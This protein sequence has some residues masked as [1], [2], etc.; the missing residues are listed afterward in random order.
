MTDRRTF[1]KGMTA[2]PAT[3]LLASQTGCTAVDEAPV[4]RD[5]LKELGV[6]PFINAAAAYS[7]LGGRNMWPAVVE[8]MEY[9]RNQNVIME[10]LQEAVG[11]RLAELIGC[12]AAMVTGGATSSM[13]LGTAACIT[14]IEPDR[15]RR[16]PDLRGL[17]NEVIVQKSHRFEYDHGVRNAGV[18]FVEIETADELERAINDNTVMMFFVYLYEVFSDEPGRI[19]LEEFA[20][21]GRK[22]GIPTLIDGSNTVPPMGRLSEYL[23][24]GFDLGCFSGGKGLRGPYSAGMLLGREDLIA[25]ARLNA[26]PNADTVG[27]GMKVSKEEVLGMLV[28]ME[29]SQQYDYSVENVRETRLVN[30]IAEKLSVLPG[31][32]TQV[33]YPA[34]EGGRPHLQIFWDESLIPLSVEEAQ[35]AL[36]D[37]EPSIRTPYLVL[38]D[39]QLEVGTAMLKDHEVDVVVRRLGEVLAPRTV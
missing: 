7:A 10:E 6:R 34:T 20:A 31:I 33:S 29:F 24:A 23:D 4:G 8:A 27:R 17:K 9:A 2:L 37:G 5:Y 16:V 19:G 18:H 3:T 15:I 30:L 22:H 21:L 11:A 14:G 35:K 12:E 36:E 26:T 1:L 13:T 38:S 25:A 28:A 39:G 32:T